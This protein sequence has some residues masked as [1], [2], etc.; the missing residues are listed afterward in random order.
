MAAAAVIAPY[1][2][3]MLRFEGIPENKENVQ[4]IIIS[5]LSFCCTD[6]SLPENG[7]ADVQA[8]YDIPGVI[9]GNGAKSITI[10]NCIFKHLGNYAIEF[11]AACSEIRILGNEIFD[12]GAGGVKLG[13]PGFEDMLN[14]RTFKNTISNNHIHHI[15]EVYPAACAVLIMTSGENTI[16]H[17]HIHD[18]YYTGISNGWS[19]G[20]AETP[21][22]NNI[23]E[24]N[25]IHD[26]GRGMLSDMGGN[27]NL[28]VQPGSVIRNNVIYDVTSYGYG[29][30]GIYTDEGSSGILIE[31]NTVYRTKTGGFHQHYG[32]ENIVR[33]NIFAFAKLGQVI[34]TRME[35]HVSFTFERNIVYWDEGPLLGG[36]WKDD[37][38]RMDNN[39][40]W[41]AKGA[42]FDF[43]GFP[44]ADWQKRGQ[45]VHS[46]IADPLF[47][48]PYNG[49]FSL[50]P[51]SPAFKLGFKPIDTSTVGIL[52]KN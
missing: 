31:N 23:I 52:K 10:E 46:I 26:I 9:V 49:N 11:S 39:L 30:W 40:Y 20:Y 5:G 1:A 6:W 32:R 18:T 16:S 48:D 8:A 34:R 25:L 13:L 50:K 29:G 15:G 22:R 38:Y 14:N 33:N 17:N 45:D 27:Y 2:R 44:F 43:A 35:E 28:G 12:M 47:V 37:K 3:E 36:N 41:Q 24:Y 21:T 19:W 51:D 42:P 4:N 7:Y